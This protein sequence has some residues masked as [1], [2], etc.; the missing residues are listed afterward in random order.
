MS[1]YTIIYAI[2]AYKLLTTLILPWWIQRGSAKWKLRLKTF[3]ANHDGKVIAGENKDKLLFIAVPSSGAGRAMDI[4]DEC[5]EEL[6]KREENFT[7]EVYVTKSSDDIKNL[8]VSKDVSGYYGIIVLGGDSSITELIQAPL[9]RNNGK[10]MY[11]PILHLPG[12]STN[13]LSKELH[14]MKS[15]KEILRQFSTEKVMRAGV[16]KL[17][18]DGDD[19]SSI[20]ATHVAFHGIGRHMLVEAEKHRHGMYSVF[21]TPALMS[22]ILKTVF[23]PPNKDESPYF[24]LLIAS[25]RNFAGGM[26]SGFGMDLFDD[27]LVMLHAKQYNGPFRYIKELMINMGTGELVRQYFTSTLPE[28]VEVKIGEKFTFK[29]HDFH[30]ILDGTSTVGQKGRTVTVESVQ[31]SIP[32]FV[33]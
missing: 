26:D 25:T 19:S 29:D 30:F 8:V 17:S 21:G 31:E 20:Y 33:L 5:I 13:L 22:L 2:I 28:G 23:S 12:G 1:P 24:A 11:P 10:W 15:H 14:G 32:Y 7:I 9:R 4:Y 16:I 3:T 27:K 18:T 6:Q